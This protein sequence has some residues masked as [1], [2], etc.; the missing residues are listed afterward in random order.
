MGIVN[1]NIE[2]KNIMKS[3]YFALGLTYLAEK[4][5]AGVIKASKVG[6]GWNDTADTFNDGTIE[7]E[8]V[9]FGLSTDHVTI[10]G[11]SSGGFLTTDLLAMFNDYLDGGAIVAAGGPC[12]SR[13][14]CQDE[15]PMQY[16]T[17]GLRDKKIYF[18][19]GE[20]DPIVPASEE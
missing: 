2:L 9:D 18:A 6:Y 3:V 8:D 1:S 5:N 15:F 11:F 7:Y 16:D 19:F 13:G 4:A 10:S 20:V 14:W 17:S 12:A